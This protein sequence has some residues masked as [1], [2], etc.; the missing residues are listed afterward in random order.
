VSPLPGNPT[1]PMT[2][3]GVCGPPFYQTPMSDQK[4]CDIGPPPSPMDPHPRVEE[5][6]LT[7]FVREAP[8][9]PPFRLEHNLSIS[10]FIFMLASH[11][12]SQVISRSVALQHL[13]QLSSSDHRLLEIK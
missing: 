9:M 10:K 11:D 2:P 1:P 3:G 6:R 8:I 4:P 12:Y 7:F 13:Y 5:P